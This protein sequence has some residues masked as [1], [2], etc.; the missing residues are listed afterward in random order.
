MGFIAL[1]G[2]VLRTAG[3][4]GFDMDELKSNAAVLGG[5]MAMLQLVP[6]YV[7]RL[8]KQ[9]KA[10]AAAAQATAESTDAKRGRTRQRSTK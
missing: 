5:V 6:L 3:E 1:L 9:R 7:I 8:Q 10:K 4:S 2:S